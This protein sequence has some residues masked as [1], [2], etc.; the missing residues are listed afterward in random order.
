LTV[1]VMDA[2]KISYRAKPPRSGKGRKVDSQMLE[3]FEEPHNYT[4]QDQQHP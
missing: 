4:R 1:R 2:R 3:G